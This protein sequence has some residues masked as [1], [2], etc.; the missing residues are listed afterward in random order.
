MT[1]LAQQQMSDND[2]RPTLALDRLASGD[3]TISV[4]GRGTSVE[5]F[6]SA[7]GEDNKACLRLRPRIL[8][9]LDALGI[10][11]LKV[12][13][14]TLDTDGFILLKDMTTHNVRILYGAGGF[15]VVARTGPHGRPKQTTQLPIRQ[16]FSQLVGDIR[17]ALSLTVE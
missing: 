7:V 8:A 10:E 4:P 17:L 9:A 16:L 2:L 5:D 12:I 15:R 11:S 13:N 6:Y 1:T 3:F 14:P